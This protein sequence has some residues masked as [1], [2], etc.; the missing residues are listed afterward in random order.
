MNTLCNNWEYIRNNV[1][2]HAIY[3]GRNPDE[4]T[5]LAVSKT[6]PVE[7]IIEGIKCGIGNFGE[8]YAQEFRDKYTE[9]S[10]RNQKQPQWHFI[11]H[12][13]TNKVKY[14]IPQCEY[15]HTVDSI[16]L[17]EEIS[18]QSQKH[19]VETKILL[20]INTS[21]ELSKSGIEPNDI[22]ELVHNI[23]GMEG[24]ILD[25]LMCIPAPEEEEA[26][27]A[28]F[29]LLRTLCNELS[30]KISEHPWTHLSMGMSGDYKI[31]IEEG[32]TIVR[33]GTAIFG[34]RDY[35]LS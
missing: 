31:A 4:I 13:Q 6:H 21:G 16:R 18:K 23:A 24:I 14:I 3:C 20:Q 1:R 34:E 15:I 19:S 9:I 35:S 32:S 10:H 8:N 5:I 22:Y 28:E 17:A 33:I 11:G 26:I 7:K 2:E 30:R 27:R 29:A 25:G 12:L